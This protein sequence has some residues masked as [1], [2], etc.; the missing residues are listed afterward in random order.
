MRHAAPLLLILFL[1]ACGQQEGGGDPRGTSFGLPPGPGG[2]DVSQGDGRS[3][4][5]TPLPGDEVIEQ[6]KGMEKRVIKAVITADKATLEEL[7]APDFYEVTIAGRASRSELIDSLVAVGPSEMVEGDDE[8]L[9]VTSHQPAPGV[10]ML[11]YE[12]SNEI[13]EQSSKGPESPDEVKVTPLPNS[14]CTSIWVN[15]DGK[16]VNVLYHLTDPDPEFVI[17]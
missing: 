17:E 11:T 10:V 15:R 6:I 13:I 9:K 16:W 2:T 5:T 14:I 4:S 8:M 12:I 7:L 3:P 1:V